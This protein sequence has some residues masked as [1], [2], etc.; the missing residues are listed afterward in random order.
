[1]DEGN[2]G[3]YRAFESAWKLSPSEQEAMRVLSVLFSSLV[4]VAF[5][6]ISQS[7]AQI[8]YAQ[9]GALG[10]VKIGV[11]HV[12]TV[13]CHDVTR[14]FTT[15]IPDPDRL[16]KSYRGV[17]SGI[18]AHETEANGA[19][20]AYRNFSFTNGGRAVSYELYA[21]GQGA[22]VGPV[23][24]NL[25]GNQVCTGRGVCVNGAGGSEGIELYAHYKERP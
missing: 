3:T 17:L 25:I 21:K 2:R 14:Q 7:F 18:E 16:D 5:G 4:S 11:A 20:H 9:E 8:S 10:R 1:M 6:Q 23:C 12:G 24:K 19:E 13:G 15:E 22:W